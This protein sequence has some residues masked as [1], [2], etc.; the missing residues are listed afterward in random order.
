MTRNSLAGIV[1]SLT[2]VIPVS[3]QVGST[4]PSF[5]VASIK[6]NNSGR[7]DV[8]ISATGT[9]RLSTVG[10]TV[11]WLIG[12]AYRV[13]DFQ[14]SGGPSWVSNDR[15]D[16]EARAE[17][18]LPV[19]PGREGLLLRSLLADRFQLKVRSETKELPIYE[20]LVA[21][22]G[23][24]LVAVPE[25][26]R[27]GPGEPPPP[28]GPSGMPAPG[29]FLVRIGQMRGSAVRIGNLV[30][31]LSRQM[32]RTVVDETGLT[33]FFDIHLEWTPDN[34]VGAGQTT[35]APSAPYGPSI[36][37]ALQEQLG[38]RL[39]SSKGPVEVIIID[40]VERPSEN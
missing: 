29:G 20:L 33:G 15:F 8:L 37:T 6:P 26:K 39:D 4:Q 14:V 30:D 12:M 34:N 17:N 28:P 21:K 13:R 23:S 27:R 40:S 31:A 36:F 1:L 32:S 7:D 5:E 19:Q 24:K 22:S 35:E 3:S 10:T 25:P 11:K 9:G 16:I 18:G 2:V 38:L